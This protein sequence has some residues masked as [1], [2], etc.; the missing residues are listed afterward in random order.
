[1]FVLKVLG[2]RSPYI[3]AALR[4]GL[5]SAVQSVDQARKESEVES[6]STPPAICD[7]FTVSSIWCLRSSID[8]P[9][10]SVGFGRNI[11]VKVLR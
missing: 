6:S 5:E 9:P 11:S 1:M 10:R 2:L 7:Y 3:D 4:Y 8:K